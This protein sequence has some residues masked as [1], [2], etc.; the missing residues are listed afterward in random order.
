MFLKVLG[1]GRNDVDFSM[2][3]CQRDVLS[4]AWQSLVDFRFLIYV[5]EAWQ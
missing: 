2:A 5:C 1:G 4:T 3:D